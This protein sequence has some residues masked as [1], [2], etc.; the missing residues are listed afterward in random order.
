MITETG[1][2]ENCLDGLASLDRMELLAVISAMY[3]N[4]YGIIPA[5]MRQWDHAD[6]MGWFTETYIWN[7]HTGH[8]VCTGVSIH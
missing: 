3:H 4:I 6:L 8:F 7:P 5:H 2:E 1:S